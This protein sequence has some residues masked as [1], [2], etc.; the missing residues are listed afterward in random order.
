MFL[1][2][3]VILL[4]QG[5]ASVHSG[6]PPRKEAPP[7]EGDPREGGTSPLGKEAPPWEG[8]PP[9]YGQSK[10]PYMHKHNVD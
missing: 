2:A 8:D 1:L 4:T 5:S 10:I 6:I 7:W 9:A 3:S